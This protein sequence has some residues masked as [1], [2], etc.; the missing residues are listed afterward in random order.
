[1][2]LSFQVVAPGLSC[3]QCSERPRWHQSFKG[4]V[5]KDKGNATAPQSSSKIHRVTFTEPTSSLSSSAIRSQETLFTPGHR[6]PYL[7]CLKTW[8]HSVSANHTYLMTNF[9]SLLYI[10][11]G[12]LGGII[13][14]WHHTL[15]ILIPYSMLLAR[16]H[17]A[18]QASMCS[19]I[20]KRWQQVQVLSE[21]RPADPWGASA[22]QANTGEQQ[23]EHKPHFSLLQIKPDC[24]ELQN[25]LLL[26]VPII[27]A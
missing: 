12:K 16:K 27:C 3:V 9:F 8:P 11:L 21:T 7:P 18:L 4:E 10:K 25:K 6:R 15:C 14:L 23:P 22:L 24:H 26:F 5:E 17:P 13:Y 2:T 1:M 19:A 20:L